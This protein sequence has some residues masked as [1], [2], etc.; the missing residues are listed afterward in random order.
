MLVFY[1]RSAAGI[2]YR[3]V[4]VLQQRSYRD[5]GVGVL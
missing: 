3:G 5:R 1:T 4:G 2:A